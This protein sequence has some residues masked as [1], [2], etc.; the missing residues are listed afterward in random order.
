MAKTSLRAGT[1]ARLSASG[2]MPYSSVAGTEPTSTP[3][4][5]I[6][7]STCR[8]VDFNNFRVNILGHGHKAISD[9][10]IAAKPNGVSFGN[11]VAEEAEL[12]SILIEGIASVEKVPFSRSA[13]ES[14][15]TAAR[16]ARAY[17][18]RTKIA[19]F[20]GGYQGFTD[21]VS[22]SV[23]THEADEYGTDADPR[24]VADDSRVPHQ[25]VELVVVLSQNDLDG[26]ERVLRGHRA[27]LALR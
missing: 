16:I 23:H 4:T 12:A 27:E 7:L 2:T 24:P 25:T 1:A 10:L 14:V 15:I 9:D 26:I 20:E 8:L 17:R 19:K 6:D 5:V 21:P 3:S 18:G 22:V 13:S 11:P